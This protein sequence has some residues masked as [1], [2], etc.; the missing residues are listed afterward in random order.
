MLQVVQLLNLLL[1][2]LSAVETLQTTLGS[3]GA[4]HGAGGNARHAWCRCRHNSREQLSQCDSPPCTRAPKAH[5]QEVLRISVVLP[6]PV[7]LGKATSYRNGVEKS[8]RRGTASLPLA[9]RPT[10]RACSAQ[11]CSSHSLAWERAST[12]TTPYKQ[13]SRHV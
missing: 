5:P 6:V 1:K 7:D 4:S 3:H 12:P 10:S 2:Q 13:F 11:F 8:S 9:M